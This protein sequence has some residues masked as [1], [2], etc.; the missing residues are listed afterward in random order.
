[1]YINKK[2]NR[3]IAAIMIVIMTVLALYPQ[4]EGTEYVKAAK[5]VFKLTEGNS[6]IITS[7]ESNKVMEVSDFGIYNGDR[8]QQWDYSKE[9]SQQWQIKAEGNYY[10]FINKNSQKLLSTEENAKN[11]AALYQWDD[12][13]ADTQLWYLEET[14]DGYVQIK[15]KANKKCIDIEGISKE[16]GAKL[17]VWEDVDGDNQKWKFTEIEENKKIVSGAKYRIISKNSKK[18]VE[19]GYNSQ[20][21]GGTVQQWKYENGSNQ[22]WFLEK[23]EDKYYKI[24]ADHSGKVLTVKNGKIEN[25]TLVEQREYNGKD[26]QLWYLSEDPN[27]YYRIRSKQSRKALDVKD[28]SQEN[29]ALLQIWQ[30]DD[31]DNQKWELEMVSYDT[32]PTVNLYIFYN[33]EE[34]KI[35]T[36]WDLTEDLI[37][38]ELYVR[39]DKEKEFKKIATKK[40]EQSV[41]EDTEDNE[42]VSYEETVAADNIDEYADFRVVGRTKYGKE[43][44]SHVVSVR[45][46]KENVLEEKVMDSDEDGIA[47]G[48]EIWDLSTDPYQKDT[49]GDGFTD[50]YEVL[51]LCTNPLEKTEDA[52]YDEDG[53]DNFEEMNRGTNPYMADS[54][55]D[56]IKD[57]EDTEPLKTDVNSKKEAE[58]DFFMPTGY[59]DKKL[60]GYDED[61]EYYEYIYNTL[62]DV[63]RYC[64]TGEDNKIYNIYDRK[65]NQT[66]N[67]AS[68]DGKNIINTYQYDKDGNITYITHNGFA[69]DFAYDKNGNMTNAKVGGQ[70]LISVDYD[71]TTNAE[72]KIK[73]AN[74]STKEY[75]YDETGLFATAVKVDGKTAYEYQYDE[76][77][78][79]LE[80]KDCENGIVYSYEYR[81]G[82]LTKVKS[83]NGFVIKNEN[84]DTG[85]TKKTSYEINGEKRTQSITESEKDK[86]ISTSLLIGGKIV[87]DSKDDNKKESVYHADGKEI[88]YTDVAINDKKEI[89]EKHQDGT[90]YTY[91]YDKNGNI[92]HV[93]KNSIL[94]RSYEYDSFNQLIRENNKDSNQTVV[95]SYNTG[96]NI[97]SC[98]IYR[99]TLDSVKNKKCIQ[100]DRYEYKQDGWK[101]ILTSV[102]G[103]KISCDGIGNPLKYKNSCYFTWKNGRELESIEKDGVKAEYFYNSQGIR[104]Q[105]V[106]NGVKTEYH[107]DENKIV[108]ETTKNNT[109]WYSYDNNNDIVGFEKEGRSYY[110]KKNILKDIIGICNE[111]GEE[112]V[113]Y[114]YD[115]W[116]NITSIIGDKELGKVNP[117]RYRSYYYDEESELYY[118]QSRY[119]DSNTKRFLNADSH[120]DIQANTRWTNLFCYCAN[121]PVMFADPTGESV[122]VFIAFTVGIV[123]SVVIVAYALAAFWS[124]WQKNSSKLANGLSSALNT[125]GGVNSSTF[126]FAYSKA[127][128]LADAIGESFAKA[129]GKAKPD[130]KSAREWHHIVARKEALAEPAREVLKKLKIDV[131]EDGDNLT[132]IKTG[133][134][135][136]LHTTVYYKFV[137]KI[138]ERAEE[139]GKTKLEKVRN[140]RLALRFIEAMIIGLD[141]MAPY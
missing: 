21:D 77:G 30:N 17:Q 76:D 86:R 8:L 91:Q 136:R 40:L 15:S 65:G 134:H 47:D 75:V 49:D 37:E 28:R 22:Q 118:L 54:D 103:E 33:E 97:V 46:S 90:E 13:N 128:T 38:S 45:K 135:K 27:G 39:Y 20:E 62:L 61:G 81:E 140:V 32:Y 56:G 72:K 3:G 137:N 44:L 121:N 88:L 34:K 50:G 109:I 111:K 58:C 59:Y 105:K 19:V 29:G 12:T 23:A 43:I 35:E 2:A 11:G 123:V 124:N 74:G 95:Y 120:F 78:N 130:Y 71:N 26:N 100:Q 53:L 126:S 25:G 138:V 132:Y 67:I 114:S 127:K 87:I 70:Q 31:G 36:E 129:K 141:K 69:Y 115:A 106:V 102:N 73:Y 66:G 64:Q 14:G 110:Y 94:I 1:M 41:E 96:G 101:D 60:C 16:N 116:G 6:Y 57:K 98:E 52:D 42:M 108:G 104:T 5:S 48:Y 89:V 139:C 82:Q 92:T 84:N 68:S 7:K 119:Y 79:L 9:E 117:F 10:K 55:L 80:E 122:T 112:I 83:N 24:I 4:K 131:E 125:L 85:K 93:Y 63:Y 99:Y 107:L 51:E 113:S 133:L 18:A